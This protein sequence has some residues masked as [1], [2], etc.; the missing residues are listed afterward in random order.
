MIWIDLLIILSKLSV[1]IINH[2][3]SMMVKWTT[4]NLLVTILSNMKEGLVKII[5]TIEGTSKLKQSECQVILKVM[6]FIKSCDFFD[7]INKRLEMG[8][9]VKHWSFWDIGPWTGVEVYRQKGGTLSHGGTRH[10]SRDKTW[11]HKTWSV[12]LKQK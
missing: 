9:K 10:D 11:H 7:E 1:Q 12:I 2:S 3:L 6:W 8:Q 4:C 5:I